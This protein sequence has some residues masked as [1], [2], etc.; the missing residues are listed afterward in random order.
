MSV[1]SAG[2]L[3][4]ESEETEVKKDKE[5]LL[6]EIERITDEY[7]NQSFFT[8][9]ARYM[10]SEIEEA[11]YQLDEPEVL[12][13]EWID[14][15]STNLLMSSPMIKWVEASKLQNLLVPKQELP[16]IPQFVADWI[17]ETKKQRKSLVFA[18]TYI[19]DK[20]EIG[21]SPNKEE[22]RIFQWMELADNEE[23]FAR[24]WLD[25]YEV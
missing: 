22:N 15:N 23:V 12:S 4:N 10:I 3:R 8:N 5:W 19:Y 14:E 2:K 20:N 6:N 7:S 17:E 13:Q 11:V 1:R 25:G 24:A 16:T 18:I 21:K 9:F